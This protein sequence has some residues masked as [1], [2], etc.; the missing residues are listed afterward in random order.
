MRIEKCPICQGKLRVIKLKCNSCKT[1]IEGNFITS[2]LL[3]LPS[4]HQEFIELFVLSSGSLK[5]MSRRLGV[6]YPTVRS[7]LNEIISALEEEIKKKEEY[8]KEILGK[9]ER[10]KISPEEAA[11]IIKGL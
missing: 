2:S 3:N 11:D 8:K 9:I 7:R 1:S 5:E 4:A 6:S 10:G